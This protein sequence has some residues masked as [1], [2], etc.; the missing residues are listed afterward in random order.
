MVSWE[1]PPLVVGGLGRHVGQLA[2]ELSTLGH[3]V[4]V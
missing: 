1:F 3:D 2:R 4:R